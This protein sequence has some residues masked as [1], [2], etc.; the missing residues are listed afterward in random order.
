MA[1][2]NQL[3]EKDFLYLDDLHVGQRFVSGTHLIDEEQIKA[4]AKQFDPQPFHLDAEAAKDTLFGGLVASGW[5]TA[6]ISMR[7]LVESGLS[8]AGGIVGVG[9]EIAWPKPTR[10]DATLHVE[11]EILE[12][13]PSRS[14]PDR[15]VAT[16]RSE[17]RN[18]VGEIVQVFIAKLVVS[19]RTSAAASVEENMAS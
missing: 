12:L 11:S 14:R 10:P 6:A 7:L 19:R 9:G 13:R 17:T 1:N 15:G 4:F 3:G 18:Q 5:H 16:I 2:P 8:I